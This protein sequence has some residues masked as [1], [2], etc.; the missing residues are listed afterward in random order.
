[1]SKSKSAIK[2]LFDKPVPFQLLT[3]IVKYGAKVNPEN[4]QL[5]TKGEK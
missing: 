2:I 4:A 1:L 5:K 3:K